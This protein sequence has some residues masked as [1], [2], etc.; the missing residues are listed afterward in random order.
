MFRYRSEMS[1]CT[2]IRLD[3]GVSQNAIII[4]VAELVVAGRT[5]GGRG[6]VGHC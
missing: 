1:K 6:G 2:T 4:I 5:A 3:N